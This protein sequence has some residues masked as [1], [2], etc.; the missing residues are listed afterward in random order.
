MK[1][2]AIILAA[3]ATGTGLFAQDPRSSYS[4][5]TDFT[6]TSQYVFRGLKRA[7]NSLQPSVEVTVQDFYLGLWTN[8]PVTKNQDNELDV[9]AGY[10]YKVN[11]NLSVEGVGTYYWYPEANG[12]LTRRSWEAGIGA[13]YALRGITTS[14]YYYHDFTLESNTLQG[15]VGYSLPLEAIGASLDFTGFY[16]AVDIGNWTPRAPGKVHE[17]YNYYGVDASLPYKLSEKATV[18][19]G[20]HWAHNDNLPVGMN[21]N[22]I[23]WTAGVTVGF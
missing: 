18:T 16:G 4:V 11:K 2:I 20:A 12:W 13:T 1:N 21:D 10:K 7:G 23:W 17:S 8:Q 14:V 6:Y 15:S 3:L 9:Y 19:L 22:Y 5:T